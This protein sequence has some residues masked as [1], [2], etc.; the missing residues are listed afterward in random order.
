MARNFKGFY[1]DDDGDESLWIDEQFTFEVAWEVANKVGGIYTV[2]K[3]K[4]AYSVNTMGDNYCLLG[5][6]VDS[7]VRTEVEVLSEI[8]NLALRDTIREL[9]DNG[10]RVAYGRW[11]IDGY[12]KVVLFDL[13]ST[14]WR[15]DGAKQDFWNATH[16]GMPG[17]SEAENAVL[18][19]HIVAWFIGSYRARCASSTVVVGHFHE[20]Q[21]GVGLILLRTRHVDVATVF[22]THATLLGRYLCASNVD[23]YNNLSNFDVDKEAGERNIYH[24]YCME[25]SAAHCAH[26]FTTVSSI[27]AD[28]AMHLLKRKADVVVPNGLNVVRFSAMHE[29]QNLHAKSKEKINNFVQGHF[30]GFYDFDLD[31]TLYFFSAGR[32]EYTNKG[33]DLY[34]ESL[35]QL[36]H[37][38]K[39]MRSDVTVVAFLIFPT[40]TSNFNV[41][42]LR[43]QACTKQLREVVQTLQSQVGRRIFESALGGSLPDTGD[44]LT[45]EDL[46]KLKRCIYEAQRPTLPAVVT[47]N[48]DNDATDPILGTIRRLGLFNSREDRVKVIFHPEFL[49]STNP[50]IGMDYEEFVRGCHLGVFPSYYEPWGYTPAECT[51]MGIPSVTTNLS[52]FGCFM[53][54]EVAT[55]EM[56]GIYIVDRRRQGFQGSV[57][58]LATNMLKFCQFNR[59]QRIIQRNRTERLSEILDWDHL[60]RHYQQARRLAIAQVRPDDLPYSLEPLEYIKRYPKPASVADSQSYQSDVDDIDL[61]MEDQELSSVASSRPR[62]PASDGASSSE[63]LRDDK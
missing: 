10:I 7:N 51:L 12:P 60:G 27:T 63:A 58:E 2:I 14:R 57:Q 16:I 13:E 9:E 47:H 31:K 53:A 6:Y 32:Y 24:R 55:P 37:Q 8:P 34:L 52:G 50:L 22:T 59:R 42:S 43:S 23:F 35:A 56:Y 3:S 25:R 38:L 19:G 30:S 1:D 21:A 26:T 20:W 41:D 45:S 4:A 40:K 15:T 54:E 39:A 48:V 29:F 33:V 44:L 36:N 18:F 62:S 49:K 11:L 46:L 5:P 17:D 28:E 61:D